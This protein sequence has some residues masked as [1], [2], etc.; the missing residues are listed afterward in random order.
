MQQ[1]MNDDEV[2]AHLRENT[3]LNRL[4]QEFSAASARIEQAG[5]QKR[6]ASPVEV[7]RMEFEAVVRILKM[8]ESLRYWET[9]NA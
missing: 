8:A 6:P 7:R 5:Q 1:R 3:V 4:R 9:E 2:M